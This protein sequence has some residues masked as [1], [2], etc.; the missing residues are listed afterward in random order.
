[1][2]SSRRQF[3]ARSAAGVAVVAGGSFSANSSAAAISPAAATSGISTRNQRGTR[4][5]A[6]TDVTVIDVVSGRR[7]KHQT[8]LI[9]GDRII[10]VGRL[11]VP[12]GA[13]EL[14]LSGKFVIPGL[15]DM[16]VHSLGDKHVSPPLYLAN[17]LTTVREMAAPDPVL[18]DWRDRIEAGTLLGPR[19]VVAS[20]IIDGDP[21]LWDPN[22]L[23]VLV[24]KDEAGARAAVR[25]VKGEGADFV[26]VYSRLSPTAYRAILDEAKKQGLTVH[27]HAPDQV[28]IKQVSA[29]G[30][31][32][33][34]HIHSLA[35][36]VS[37]READVRRMQRAITVKTGDYN[38]W[39][40]QMHPIE[41]IAANTYSPARAAD[42][43]GTLRR[44]R[45]RVTPTLTMHHALDLPDFT[46]PD[47][48][49]L[50]YLSEDSIGTFEYVMDT[51]YKANRG[52]EEIA[53]QQQMWEYRQRFVRELFAHDVPVLAGTDTGTPYSVP[54]FALHDEL[55]LLVGAGA[56]TR[57]ALAAATI[58]PARFLG[59]NTGT[60]EPR[61]LAD[62]VVLDADPLQDIRNTRRIHSVIT[63][64]RVISPAARQKML[65]DV[66][67]AVK[68]PPSAAAIAT[69]G[70]CG[71]SRPA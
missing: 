40:R 53:H 23:H 42:V 55:E 26:K 68:Q 70:C 11:P 57:Q 71:T 61:K 22:L 17:G 58:E 3:L 62:L 60:V 41:W 2:N 6:L 45:T 51:L 10:G 69:G 9:S 38:G 4:I 43:F 33:I 20:Q 54:G 46:G 65:A 25:L 16:H 27:G 48:A 7:D 32:S 24:V 18:Y 14:N 39:F 67:T 34:E 29:A 44:N 8:V 49:T 15:A 56:S 66:E 63:R 64:G 21:T 1:M 5:T 52:A 12:R 19:M 36:S 35:L 47:P 30:Q 31:R 37:T 50:K 28:S 59:L 13:I